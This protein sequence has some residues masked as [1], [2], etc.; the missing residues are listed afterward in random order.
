MNRILEALNVED[1]RLLAERRLPS[2][3]FQYVETG[4]GDGSGVA[5]NVEGFAKHLMLARCLQKVVPPDTSRTIFGHRYALPFGISAVGAMG[6]FHPS[7][8][9]YLAEVARDFNIPFILSGMSTMSID[10]IAHIA[11]D[12]VW[13]QL[14]APRDFAITKQMMAQARNAG[15][16]VLV[17]SVD[18]PVPN[19]S[20]IPL[21]TG[22]S[23]TG[24]INWR[25]GPA[26]AVDLL[27]HPG[28]LAK[29]LANGGVPAMESWKPYAPPGSN[30]AGISKFIGGAW[31]ANLVWTDIEKIR[32][33]WPGKLV[34]KGLLDPSDV[35]QA[36][37][38]GADAV[39]LSNHGGNK[40]DILPASVDCL[41]G[42]KHMVP[43][44][45][46]LF[47]DGGIRRGSDI[48]KAAALGADFCFLGRAFLYGVSASGKAGAERVATI[49]RNEL[50]YAQAMLGCA[51]LQSVDQRLLFTASSVHT[52]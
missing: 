17:V 35:A 43:D 10:D 38:T 8:D 37:E 16:D 3:L 50:S 23:L 25:K 6:M 33:L 27:R 19:H 26:I 34:I 28:W 39:T 46:P 20:E 4:H 52:R 36:Y 1:L 42:A 11:P 29:F 24:G 30:A 13:Y 48:L 7:A 5:R 49:L 51:D 22:V 47:F 45:A 12:H 44:A 32:A 9:R 40:L 2:F 18:Y 31:P 21:R 15:V 41:A 14:Y